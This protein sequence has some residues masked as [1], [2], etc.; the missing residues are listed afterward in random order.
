MKCLPSNL[1]QS[2]GDINDDGISDLA[3]GMPYVDPIGHKDDRM[4]HVV[5]GSESAQGF[6]I[7]GANPD[8]HFGSCICPDYFRSSFCVHSLAVLINEGYINGELRKNKG[9]GRKTD[10]S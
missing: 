6:R 1:I 9:R 5:F 3:I 10:C 7:A 4:V 8:D 2:A